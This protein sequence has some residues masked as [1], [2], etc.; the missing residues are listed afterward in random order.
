MSMPLTSQ[1]VSIL[2]WLS[3]AAVVV[4]GTLAVAGARRSPSATTTGRRLR[5]VGT[6]VAAVLA[7][8][9]TV[10]QAGEIGAARHPPHGQPALPALQDKIRLLEDQLMRLKH[11]IIMR[12]V[13]PDTANK[14]A[15]YLRTFGSHTV[16]VSCVPNDIEAYDYAT[17]IINVLKSAN[18]DARGPEITTIF[19]NVEAMGINVYDDAPDGGNTAKILLTGFA[20]FNIPFQ[21]RVA[22]GGPQADPVVELFIGARPIL[23]AATAADQPAE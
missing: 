5:L 1:A 20:K 8:T 10:W 19:G 12:E 7:V 22:S 6:L 2:S 17:Q 16:V 14:L 11:S 9:G 3:A 4:L 13:D 18:W 23:H 15:E 21:T